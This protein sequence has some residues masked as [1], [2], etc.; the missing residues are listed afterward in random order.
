M[1]NITWKPTVRQL[2]QLHYFHPLPFTLKRV[3]HPQFIRIDNRRY[4]KVDRALHS[5]I[6]IHDTRIPLKQIYLC[7]ATCNTIDPRYK[8]PSCIH[9]ECFQLIRVNKD[10]GQLTT[11]YIDLF[12]TAMH[13]TN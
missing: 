3:P 7:N 13:A 4:S 10:L 11:L 8:D 2:G 9:C 1:T 12:R 6:V 5:R